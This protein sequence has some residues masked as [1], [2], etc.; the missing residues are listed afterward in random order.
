MPQ[1]SDTKYWRDCRD[2]FTCKDQLEKLS[3]FSGSVG[4][5]YIAAGLGWRPTNQISN[6]NTDVFHEQWQT[7]KEEL[8]NWMLIQPTHY[9]YLK[10]SIYLK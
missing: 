7:D 3:K 5:L 10:E 1:R 4:L 8:L 2:I 6:A 9:Q